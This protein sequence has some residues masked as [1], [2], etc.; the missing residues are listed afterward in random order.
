MF[1]ACGLNTYIPDDLN[2]VVHIFTDVLS[3][4]S[5]KEHPRLNSG[6]LPLFMHLL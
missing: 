4:G 1:Y 5:S 2:P 6:D 3:P